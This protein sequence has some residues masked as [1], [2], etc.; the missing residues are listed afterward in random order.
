MPG[1]PKNSKLDRL[2]Q[3]CC[4]QTGITIDISF[5]A[6][7]QRRTPWTLFTNEKITVLGGNSLDEYDWMHELAHIL[8]AY[9]SDVVTVAPIRVPFTHAKSQA[10][11][12]LFFL[13]ADLCVD[14]L[15]GEMS[16]LP[17]DQWQK[18]IS[19]YQCLLS[20]ENQSICPSSL[21]PFLSDHIQVL[22]VL[23]S[24]ADSTHPSGCSAWLLELYRQAAQQANPLIELCQTLI[25]YYLQDFQWMF[26]RYN[27][28]LRAHDRSRKIKLLPD[29]AVS[30]LP[31]KSPVPIPQWAL[32]VG[33]LIKKGHDFAILSW[34]IE[35][36]TG[37]NHRY[38]RTFGDQ[39]IAEVGSCLAAHFGV[40]WSRL[41]DDSDEAVLAF[42]FSGIAGRQEILI[43]AQLA[44][45]QVRLADGTS[46]EFPINVNVGIVFYPE[47]GDSLAALLN[48]LELRMFV[49][50]Y[51]REA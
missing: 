20:D 41:A 34:D 1:F 36:L 27:E 33:E 15:L 9:K 4:D 5:D 26:V 28:I 23:N 39:L 48:R 13:V 8:L 25:P 19:G 43:S 47:D 35:G 30:A 49:L 14:W 22:R 10:L 42:P 50:P 6:S 24:D 12:F 3:L 18:V 44:L 40:P 7:G 51:P 21:K 46:S 38:G 32:G 16:L 17:D 2:Y 31:K 11:Y 29:N 45:Q 37:V